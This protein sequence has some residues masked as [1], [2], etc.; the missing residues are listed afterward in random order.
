MLRRVRSIPRSSDLVDTCG[1]R[2]ET[3]SDRWLLVCL[4]RDGDQRRSG[5]WRLA[6]CAGRAGR[7]RQPGEAAAARRESRRIG[8]G[9]GGG[10]RRRSSRARATLP[11]HRRHRHGD[12]VFAASARHLERQVHDGWRRRVRRHDQQSGENNR[13]RRLCDRR[14]RHRPPGRDVRRRLGARQSGAASKFRIPRG[15]PRPRPPRRLCGTTTARPKSVRTS[16]AARMVA[17]RA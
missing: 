10:R 17:A 9:A 13:E 2:D 16:R 15:S 12:S 6:G 14:H 5:D 8:V 11:R 7:V 1:G 3:E 4:R